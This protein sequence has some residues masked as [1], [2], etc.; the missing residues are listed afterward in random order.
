MTAG[1]SEKTLKH[2]VCVRF[3]AQATEEQ[4]RRVESAF[5]RL[6]EKINSIA[7]FEA[8]RNVSVENK[9]KGFSHIWVLTFESEKGRDAYLTHPEHKAFSRLLAAVREDVLVFDYFSAGD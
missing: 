9:D 8:G 7:G 4:I 1:R 2:L 6:C 5:T 3:K